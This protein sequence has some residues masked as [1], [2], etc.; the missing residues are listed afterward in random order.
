MLANQFCLLYSVLV[1]ENSV[2]RVIGVDRN[3]ALQ[4]FHR[5]MSFDCGA[6]KAAR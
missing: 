3:I 5:G 4:K 2:V 6:N 1:S